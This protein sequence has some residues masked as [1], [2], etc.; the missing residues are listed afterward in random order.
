MF[1]DEPTKSLVD[2]HCRMFTIQYACAKSWLDCNLK[3]D[4]IIGHSLGQLTALCVAGSMLF[5]D[6]A[7]LVLER[8]RLIEKE[9]SSEPGVMLSI[10]GDEQAIKELVAKQEGIET[11]C[12][13]SPRNFVVA[14][15]A[16]AIGRFENL[17]ESTKSKAVLKFSRLKNT[18]AY[19]SYLM[20]PVLAGLLKVAQSISF[21]KSKIAVETC[22]KDQSWPEVDAGKILEH[23]RTPVYFSEAVQRIAKRNTAAL[24]LDVGCG[25][26]VT[27]MARKVIPQDFQEAHTFQSLDL[28]HNTAQSSLAL[29]TCS[30]WRAGDPVRFWLFHK[31]QRSDYSFIN[32]PPY[33]FEKHRH[34][35]QYKPM[36]SNAS[37]ARGS[38]QDATA[39]L[40]QLLRGEMQSD[41]EAV[42]A[43]NTKNNTFV[44]CCSG[45]SVV[46]HCLCPASL[47]MELVMR[48]ASTLSKNSERAAVAQIKDLEMMAPLGLNPDTRIF[49][50]LRKDSPMGSSWRFSLSS[51]L[52]SNSADTK[53]HTRGITIL[54]YGET[55]EPSSRLRSYKRL[56]GGS[57]CDEIRRSLDANGLQGNTVYTTF[58]RV[59]N[60][61]DYYQRVRGVFAKDQ[62]VVGEVSLPQHALP[63]LLDCCSDP[64][65]LDNFLQ[66]AG[67][68]LNCLSDCP[69]NELYL[70]TAM[71]DIIYDCTMDKGS[72]EYRVYSNFERISESL[73]TNDIFVIESTS[74][75][76]KVA[77][78]GVEFRKVPVAS[79]VRSL[80]RM[81]ASEG[82]D[83]MRNDSANQER[84]T[85]VHDNNRPVYSRDGFH[86]SD[87]WPTTGISG[88]SETYSHESDV[89][90]K[91]TRLLSEVAE[92]PLSDIK[93]GSSLNDLGV[94]SLLITEVLTEI[95]KCFGV[96]MSSDELYKLST[97]QSIAGRLGSSAPDGGSREG[98][99]HSD[100]QHS[101]A[102][103]KGDRSQ[104]RAHGDYS[105]SYADGEDNKPR[106]DGEQ[107]RSQSKSFAL[108]VS[109]CFQDSKLKYDAISYPTGFMGFCSKVF[110]LQSELVISYVLEAFA[111]LG[112]PVL[113][114]KTGEQLSKVQAIQKHDKVVRQMHAVLQNAGLISRHPKDADVYVRTGR[115]PTA[116]S[117]QKLNEALIEK[118]PKHA[119]EHKLLHTTGH[120]LA[121]CLSGRV[122]GLNLL[123]RDSMAR[124][125]LED[126]Y[127]N[128]P[129][130]KTGTLLLAQ[131]LSQLIREV[132]REGE[133]K[134]LE[135]G[136]GTGGTTGIL[137]ETLSQCSKPIKY[138][139]SDLSPSLITAAKKK[140]SKHG[141]MEY[142]T[143]DVEQEPPASFLAKYD[144]II[145][146]NTIH[147]TRDLSHSCTNIR[148]MLQPGGVLC[149]VELTKNLYW[150][151]LV[152]GLL[153]G[154]W[155]FND[156]REHVLA[157]E[158]RWGKCLQAA[159]FNWVD[160]SSG[161]S[162]ESDIL[163]VIAASPSK[164]PPSRSDS[165]ASTREDTGSELETEE[166][167]LI[168]SVDST[169]LLA[170]IYYPSSVDDAST[171]RPVG[172]SSRWCL[173][174]SYFVTNANIRRQPS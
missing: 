170:D 111:S 151:D 46:N 163:R 150:F 165:I 119:S 41:D 70:C 87:D 153:E 28:S 90:P 64:I 71:G 57:R 78:M 128:A 69:P 59:V 162:P 51:R 167:V 146:A 110:P 53:L 30:L 104:T 81:N 143:I 49:L 147:A 144:I 99:Y 75:D 115:N 148:R 32:L 17:L 15:S 74:G 98:Q 23:T 19:H 97:V 96:E 27:R 2:L 94:D 22:S 173:S 18:N 155:L 169:D 4:V 25:F 9:C 154:W 127:T 129:M 116:S 63:D 24:W 16:S 45:H 92:V 38:Q 91:F 135:I 76:I 136:A 158:H 61:A 124:N 72:T 77:M 33:Q 93:P 13:N 83:P 21:Q 159:G 88:K 138:T 73:V 145:S 102:H 141:F 89:L 1:T 156:G 113:L 84:S 65:A 125:L 157:D 132:D 39:P 36:I 67:L 126:V 55:N 26:S 137:L 37:E 122:D 105:Q 142:T 29:A 66:V 54:H 43:V 31:S 7:R 20:E 108:A 172:Q 164:L 44:R 10:E 140:F 68:H 161:D 42:F 133:I 60:Y 40:I 120:C 100:R 85:T 14:G 50:K 160:W 35:M 109:S 8:A 11:A 106:A 131:Y 80:S 58:A 107:N 134:L 152:F 5:E 101:Q 168:N 62:E 117:S 114:L 6:G 112:C 82:R 166:T 130:F 56:V 103:A 12:Y 171:S 3:V 139:F 123:F 48:A 149:L 86:T 79:L 52:S 174:P 95:Q 121:D 47:Y 34:W 118:F